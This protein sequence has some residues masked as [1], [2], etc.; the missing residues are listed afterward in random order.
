MSW[1]PLVCE[2]MSARA[3][4]FG[5]IGRAVWLLTLLPN[6]T[7]LDACTSELPQPTRASVAV[8]SVRVALRKSYIRHAKYI[9][10]CTCAAPNRSIL[11][12]Q[13]QD[14]GIETGVV[15][16]YGVIQ[17]P[18]PRLPPGGC[19]ISSS[20]VPIFAWRSTCRASAPSAQ[21]SKQ[22]TSRVL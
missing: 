4:L 18:P 10:A 1:P 7:R 11:M 17:L 16:S 8:W 2:R 13:T 3:V 5:S 12:P 20:R 22:A 19:V 14:L 21:Q 6:A 15:N 9:Y